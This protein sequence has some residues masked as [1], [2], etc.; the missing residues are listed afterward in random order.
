MLPFPAAGYRLRQVAIAG[1]VVL[2]SCV[3]G[4]VALALQIAGYVARQKLRCAACRAR[5][6]WCQ[7]RHTCCALASY[8]ARQLAVAGHS[9]RWLPSASYLL[10]QVVVA[11]YAVLAFCVA[12]YMVVARK[13]G[14]RELQLI[15]AFTIELRGRPRAARW[16]LVPL[17]SE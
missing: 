14:G 5:A 13:I 1:Y 3:A 11:G 17:A 4:D 9:V 16:W 7:L 2:A 8:H 6:Q 12:G 15:F 10:R